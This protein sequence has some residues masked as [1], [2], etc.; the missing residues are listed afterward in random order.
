MD[1]LF[2]HL[3]V[4]RPQR[5]LE[6]LAQGLEEKKLDIKFDHLNRQSSSPPP[7]PYWNFSW[8][9]LTS[10]RLRRVAQG[11]PSCLFVCRFI[12]VDPGDPHHCDGAWFYFY[13]VFT[14]FY[15][16]FT[17]FYLCIYRYICVLEL[18]DSENPRGDPGDP[19]QWVEE[20]RV[21]RIRLS[22]YVDLH[23]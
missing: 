17:W 23:L 2:D 15:F 5:K 21:Q 3:K 8:R 7:S 12:R 4:S 19:H 14:W 20:T 1:F 10:Q 9:P 18:P 22:R 11:Y 13:C 16:V 6:L